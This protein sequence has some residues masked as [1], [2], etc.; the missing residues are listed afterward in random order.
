MSAAPLQ[1]DEAP[2]EALTPS[3]QNLDR[4]VPEWARRC[5]DNRCYS[6]RQ[7]IL[8]RRRNHLYESPLPNPTRDYPCLACGRLR[9]DWP[10]WL[11]PPAATTHIV[12][13][14]DCDLVITAITVPD[15][16]NTPTP[17]GERPC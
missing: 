1:P 17:Q 9:V 12:Q 16:E 11:W 4:Y 10:H 15:F 3:R 14:L 6:T 5:L 13:C 7:T 8:P 2:D